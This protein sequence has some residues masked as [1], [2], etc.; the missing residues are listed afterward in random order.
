MSASGIRSGGPKEPGPALRPLVPNDGRVLGARV[1]K[2]L[3]PGQS[4]GMGHVSMSFS[5]HAFERVA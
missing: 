4:G 5:R 3:A 1:E 2:R